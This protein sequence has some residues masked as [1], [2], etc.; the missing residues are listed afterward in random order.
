MSCEKSAIQRGQDCNCN[1]TVKDNDGNLIDMTI[2][3]KA[4]VWVRHAN[5]TVIAKFTNNI[6]FTGYK[7]LDMSN[8]ATGVLSFKLLSTHTMAAPAGKL[9]YEVHLQTP[10]A[11]STDDAV[12]DL[13]S[14]QE[15]LCNTEDSLTGGMTLP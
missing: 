7:E 4:A 8:A 11:G 1:V 12:L 9:F 10:D 3:D 15:Y 13:I 5:N 2:F 14:K 6:P